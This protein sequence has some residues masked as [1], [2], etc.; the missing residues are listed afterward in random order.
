M[1]GRNDDEILTILRLCE[2]NKD[3]IAAE[4]QMISNRKLRN[5]TM[6]RKYPVETEFKADQDQIYQYFLIILG[7]KDHYNHLLT[8]KPRTVEFT[9]IQKK[10]LRRFNTL[11][12]SLYKTKSLVETECEDEDDQDEEI[13]Q[14]SVRRKEAELLE[15]IST[16]Q[17]NLD[18]LRKRHPS[19]C[20]PQKRRRC[21][22]EEVEEDQQGGESLDGDTEAENTD[23]EREHT[24]RSDK[25]PATFK[26]AGMAYHE[27]QRCLS[28]SNNV[29]SLPS[30]DSDSDSSSD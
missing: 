4:K 23:D 24:E 25:A 6:L 14:E 8:I 30:S 18:A 21:D 2:K 13:T 11:Q 10:L 15:I 16:T 3:Q 17:K 19:W 27:Y 9:L 1:G 22:D 29:T 28:G 7:E 20:T 26:N 12:T 5:V